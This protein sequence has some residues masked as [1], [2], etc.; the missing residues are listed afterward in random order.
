M[1]YKKLKEETL[2]EP[3]VPGPQGGGT[4]PRGDGQVHHG[5]LDPPERLPS[6]TR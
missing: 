1:K 3:C 6:P 2:Y 4:G 5:H